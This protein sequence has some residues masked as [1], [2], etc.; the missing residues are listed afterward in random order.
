MKFLAFEG[1]VRDLSNK[2]ILS[3]EIRNMAEAINEDFSSY[4]KASVMS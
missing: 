3:A 1:K 2:R 4:H